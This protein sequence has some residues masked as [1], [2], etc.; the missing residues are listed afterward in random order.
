[1]KIAILKGDS[2][3]HNYFASELLGIDGPEFIVIGHNRLKGKRLK[4]MFKKS[5]LTFINRVSK[6]IYYRLVGWNKYEPDFFGEF[7][8]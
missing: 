4:K 8:S 2:A 5:P 6:Y 1:M 3:R 7:R